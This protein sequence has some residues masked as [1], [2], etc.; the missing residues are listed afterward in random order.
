MEF[1]SKKRI[2]NDFF[3]YSKSAFFSSK[4][5]SY[6]IK[7]GIFLTGKID[8]KEVQHPKISQDFRLFFGHVLRQKFSPHSVFFSR[9]T[10]HKGDRRTYHLNF[11]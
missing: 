4:F 11:N 7:S 2:F 5:T 8:S 10:Y 9:R 6:L 1:I 3:K